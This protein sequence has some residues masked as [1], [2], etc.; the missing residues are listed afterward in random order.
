MDMRMPG[1][2]CTADV[3]VGLGLNIVVTMVSDSNGI[4]EQD[5]EG[6]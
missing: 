3:R 1:V 4:E 6:T 2:D 5:D